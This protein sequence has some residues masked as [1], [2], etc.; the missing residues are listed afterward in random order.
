MDLRLTFKNGVM[1]GDGSDDIGIFHIQ[2]R[3]DGVSGDCHWT[4]AYV[5][6]HS[7][8]YHGFREGKGIW[9]TWEIPPAFHGGFHIWPLCEGATEAE[10]ESVAEKEIVELMVTG[11]MKEPGSNPWRN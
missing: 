1:L 8:I 10:N 5:G 9:G 6:A 3:Y 7:V 4:K 11:K 2:G